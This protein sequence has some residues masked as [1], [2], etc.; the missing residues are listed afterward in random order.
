MGMAADVDIKTDLMIQRHRKVTEM[1]N[2][3][4]ALSLNYEQSQKVLTDK[5]RKMPVSSNLI[6]GIQSTISHAI[7]ASQA[8]D[9]KP[10][11]SS[12]VML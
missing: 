10:I 8:G 11:S 6:N 2:G 9:K 1:P 3:A 4:A 12:N 7:K 5:S